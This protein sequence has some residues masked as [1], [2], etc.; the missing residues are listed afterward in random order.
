MLRL[1]I[2]ADLIERFGAATPGAI[3][4]E[5]DVHHW[6][7]FQPILQALGELPE[8][9]QQAALDHMLDRMR[10]LWGAPADEPA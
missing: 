10:E 2:E 6:E 1:L 5:L 7:L 4:F 3:E 8:S 9:E